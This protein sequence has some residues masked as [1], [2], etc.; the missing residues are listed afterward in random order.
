LYDRIS[1]VVSTLGLEKT[2]SGSSEAFVIKAKSW[3]E[4]IKEVEAQFLDIEKAVRS[5]AEF[6]KQAEAELKELRAIYDKIE[7]LRQ[8]GINP[9]LFEQFKLLYATLLSVPNRQV[10][11]LLSALP[12]PVIV[13]KVLQQE[14]SSLILVASLARLKQNIIN[15]VRGLEIPTLTLPSSLPEDLDQALSQVASRI[16]ELED[17]LSSAKKQLEEIKSKHGSFVLKLKGVMYDVLNVLSVRQSAELSEKWV[18]LE[19][20]VPASEVPKMVEELKNFLNNKVIVFSKEEHSSS[21]VP[22]LFRYPALIKPFEMITVLF[23]YPSYTEINPTPILA[24]TFPLIFGMMFG[25]LGHGAVLLIAGLIVYKKMA[26]IT[27]KSLGLIFSMCGVF[28]ML[29]GIMFG[30]VFGL[31][32][33]EPLLFSPIH[34]VMDMIK[35][36]ILVG[37]VHITSGLILKMINE[38]HKR[39]YLDLALVEVPKLAMYM[40]G[41]YLVFAYGIDLDAWFKG[42]IVALLIPVFVLMFGKAIASTV[43]HKGEHKLIS[44]ISEYGFESF[45][46]LIR[47]LSNTVSYARIFALLIAHW[48]LTMVF[49]IIGGLASGIPGGIVLY[50]IIVVLGN[51]IVIALEGIIAFAQNLRLHFYEWFSKFYENG[52]I[53]FSPFKTSVSLS[54]S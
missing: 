21:E 27:L 15:V 39:N 18:K 43:L 53:P 46:M 33:F 29:F 47:F 30:E 3:S 48:A 6:I 11:L 22:V 7:V 28:A 20:Y 8:L 40:A 41:V 13:Q 1:Y 35:L 17:K 26:D 49:Y 9:R 36:S 31:H 42:P 10:A 54:S 45:D 44:L 19:G 25:D 5:S 4:L 32:P 51:I 14:A 37:V 16:Q 24:I 23:G 34:S 12:K 50:A 38:Y 2:S 52:G